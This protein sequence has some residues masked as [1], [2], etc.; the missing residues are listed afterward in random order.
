M[1]RLPS[2][3]PQHPSTPRPKLPI[4]TS[5]PKS[6][7]RPPKESNTQKKTPPHAPP[8]DRRE[9]QKG[10]AAGRRLC[11]KRRDVSGPDQLG[12]DV[13]KALKRKERMAITNV[14]VDVVPETSTSEGEDRLKKKARGSL[15]CT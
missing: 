4:P 1:P 9:V 5:T 7:T 12:L 8:Q 11:Q 6:N 2:T 10:P 13:T 15:S 14:D 3:K